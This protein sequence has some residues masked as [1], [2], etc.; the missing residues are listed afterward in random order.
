MDSGL[1]S[2]IEQNNTDKTLYDS[3]HGVNLIHRCERVPFPRESLVNRLNYCHFMD[4]ILLIHAR[5]DIDQSLL[6]FKAKPEPCIGDSLSC[7]W[8]DPDEIKP[9][10]GNLTFTENTVVLGEKMVSFQARFLH[11]D[12]RGIKFGLPD[13]GWEVVSRRVQRNQCN[14]LRVIIRQNSCSLQGILMDF[15]AISFRVKIIVDQFSHCDELSPDDHVEV[16]FFRGNETLFSGKCSILMHN[17]DG[18]FHYYILEPS[19]SQVKRFE[20]K[21]YRSTRQELVPQ[22]NIFFTHPLTGQKIELKVS[23][24]SGSGF[25]VEE[26]FNNAVVMP[27]MIVPDLEM[28]FSKSLRFPCVAQAVYQKKIYNDDKITVLRHGFVIIDM[29]NKCHTELSSILHQAKNQNSYVCNTVDVERLWSFFF[30]TGFLYP[31]KYIF[32]RDKIDEIKKTYMRLYT[33]NPT[34]TK[35]FIYQRNGIIL[36]HMSMLKVYNKSWMIHHHAARKSSM[37]KAGLA[38]LQQIGRYT[39]DYHRLKSSDMEYLICY[40]RPQNGFPAHVFGGAASQINNK[41]ACSVDEFAFIHYSI[42]S[43]DDRQ[44]PYGWT[45]QESDE[46]DFLKLNDYY[47]DASDGLMLQ[48]LDLQFSHAKK[49]SLQ[50]EYRSQ[51]FVFE[52]TR[53]SVKKDGKT[54]AL[55][56]VNKTDT[57]INLSDLTNSVMVF[58]L[59][60]TLF[61]GNSFNQVMDYVYSLYQ[62]ENAPLLMYPRSSAERLDIHYEKIYNLWILKTEFSDLYFKH[63]KFFRV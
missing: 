34:F 37:I 30:E 20:P 59:D 4:S 58:I 57:G 38:V 22:P 50:E 21:E 12:D 8:S 54:A 47:K 1:S 24:I 18:E 16:T 27:G 63:N 25:S 43:T 2:Q 32:L 5:N 17:H 42:R 15:S 51:G 14:G 56:N 6:S 39:L 19:S 10:L 7:I 23:D 28:I 52:R 45:L 13:E 40:Y 55:V 26:N 49:L 60:E 36:G 9:F 29:D 48:A 44:L 61:Q 31:G 46:S 62:K 11:A 3:I 33:Q 53:L 41:R 35:H